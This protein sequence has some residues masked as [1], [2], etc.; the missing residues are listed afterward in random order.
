MTVP[1]RAKEGVQP[2]RI[3]QEL[4][5]ACADRGCTQHPQHL[6]SLVQG[7]GH[8]GVHPY[9]FALMQGAARIVPDILRIDGSLLAG[10]QPAQALTHSFDLRHL[11][12]KSRMLRIYA[13][14]DQLITL[15][16]EQ[17]RQIG[18]KTAVDPLQ[19]RSHNLIQ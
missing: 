3:P 16:H 18:R 10:C 17:H 2:C 5:A 12:L 1:Q 9:A 6:C 8:E 7:Q 14:Q 13:L 19:G 4:P 15:A 11:L